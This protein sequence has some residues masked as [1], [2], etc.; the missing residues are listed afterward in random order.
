M[1]ND[2]NQYAIQCFQD[3]AKAILDMIPILDYNEIIEQTI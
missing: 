3:E 2:I 1:N